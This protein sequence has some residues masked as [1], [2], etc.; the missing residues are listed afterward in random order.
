MG[1]PSP[2]DLIE[3][4]AKTLC[5][6]NKNATTTDLRNSVE[7]EFE[8]NIVDYPHDPHL[9]ESINHAKEYLDE[10]ISVIECP[11]ENVLLYINSGIIA[12][13]IAAQRLKDAE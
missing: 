12:E 6:N 13:R 1:G 7:I 10:I 5:K 9:K 2:V 3:L 11:L 4:C 8:K